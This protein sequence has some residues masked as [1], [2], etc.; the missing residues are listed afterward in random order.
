MIPQ[1]VVADSL[2]RADNLPR[3]VR[4]II[5]LADG[6][7]E[8]I[9]SGRIAGTHRPAKDVPDSIMVLWHGF[10]LILG[11]TG[12]GVDLAVLIA[13]EVKSGDFHCDRL[14]PDA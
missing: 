2:I 6:F 9:D 13:H 10:E 7:S 1:L 5:L 14:P 3:D 12:D 8:E 4:G 11:P